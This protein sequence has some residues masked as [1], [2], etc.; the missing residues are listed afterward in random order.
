MEKMRK[1]LGSG[2]EIIDF[3]IPLN[4]MV[5]YEVI[6]KDKD[7]VWLH[8][9][10]VQELPLAEKMR[11]FRNGLEVLATLLQREPEFANIKKIS[12]MSWAISKNPKLAEAF[13]FEVADSMEG[14]EDQVAEYEERKDALVVHK[15]KPPGYAYMSKEKFIELYGHGAEETYKAAA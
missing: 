9:E 15:D 6:N 13:G 12:G 3:G 8:L 10:D 7:E 2:Y 1:L 4:K 5:A 14:L 11:L